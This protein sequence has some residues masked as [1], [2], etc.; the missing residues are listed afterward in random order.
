[1][2]KRY[3]KRASKKRAYKKRRTIRR[4]RNTIR[5]KIQRGGTPEEDLIKLIL[6]L[7]PGIIDLAFKNVGV[8]FQILTLLSGSGVRFSGTVMRLR[9]GSRFRREQRGGGIPAGVKADLLAQLKEL[10]SSFGTNPDVIKCIDSLITKINAETVDSTVSSA[11]QAAATAASDDI[12]GSLTSEITQITPEQIKPIE[13]EPLIPKIKRVLN[14]K[15]DIIKGKITGMIDIMVTNIKEKSGLDDADIECL[16]K[17]KTA[18]LGGLLDDI[19]KKIPKTPDFSGVAA[20][21]GAKI[22]ATFD[23]ASTGL[24]H[25]MNRPK[26]QS[27]QSIQVNKSSLTLP[28]FGSKTTP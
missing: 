24:T 5:R 18:I 6:K 4:L 28:T 2:A 12:I 3:S 8:L 16:K 10:K 22:N 20:E 1:M 21:A 26:D 15:L 27:Q 25:F 13:G 14:E 7:L 19:I 9:G 17:L 11:D 23:K